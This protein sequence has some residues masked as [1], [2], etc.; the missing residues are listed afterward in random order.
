M[1]FKQYLKRCALC[2]ALVQ[3]FAAQ[4]LAQEAVDLPVPLVAQDTLEWCWVA[5]AQMVLRFRG[6][7]P[8]N[9][10]QIMEM[11]YHTPPGACCSNPNRCA[12]PGTIYQVQRIIS[13]FGGGFT[14]LNRPA[15][16]SQLYSVLKQGAPVIAHLALPTGG[17][18]VVIRGINWSSG[19]PAVEINDPFFGS[20]TL[21]FSQ[22]VQIWDAGL[23]V[24]PDRSFQEQPLPR[25]AALIAPTAPRNRE[26]QLVHSVAFRSTDVCSMLS[27][28]HTGSSAPFLSARGET[29]SVGRS[30]ESKDR[31]FGLSCTVRE[32]SS[33]R[34]ETHRIS[35]TTPGNPD[36]D[37][38]SGEYEKLKEA[39]DGCI[40]DQGG[41]EFDTLGGV[42][43]DYSF[44]RSGYTKKNGDDRFSIN[45]DFEYRYKKEIFDTAIQL[46]YVKHK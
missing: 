12:I 5:S 39:I 24:E 4:G 44:E 14:Q 27:Q 17:H 26:G 3:S 30:W 23:Y 34:T 20:L 33:S 36:Y 32:A 46:Q 37:A 8:P 38:A 25:S 6:V 31:Y 1:G 21:P 15:D 2:V 29:I 19:S 41:W 35:C 16:P 10:C 11:G 13:Y 42:F 45:A 28:F 40:H 18:F 9:Q 7:D 22:L 43:D